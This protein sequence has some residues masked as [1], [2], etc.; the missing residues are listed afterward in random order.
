MTRSMQYSN[1]PS[2]GT[3][4]RSRARA[5]SF[6]PMDRTM[7]W[8]GL[9]LLVT[10]LAF[11]CGG[12]SGHT[13][14]LYPG[15][16]RPPKELAI[17]KFGEQVTS[18]R[19][20][21]MRVDKTDYDRIELLPGTYLVGWRTTFFMRPVVDPEEHGE[22][23]PMATADLVAGHEYS[24]NSGRATGPGRTKRWWFTNVTTGIDLASGTSR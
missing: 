1:L 16:E 14:K 18:L 24:V 9:I 11:G 20:E 2:T 4:P 17:L 15:P 6:A 23:G 8:L 10:L 12:K 22:P 19:I 13:Y 5:T 7:A 3:A 21:G